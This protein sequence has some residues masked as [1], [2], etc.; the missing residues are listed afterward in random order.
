ISASTGIPVAACFINSVKFLSPLKPGEAVVVIHEIQ[1]NG[2]IAFEI[3]CGARKIVGGSIT[4]HSI[5]PD[6]LN[7]NSAA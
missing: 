5:L 4:P 1:G 7:G 6:L 3:H 2:S